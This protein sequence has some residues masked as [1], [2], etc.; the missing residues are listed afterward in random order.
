MK[1]VRVIRCDL[2][3]DGVIVAIDVNPIPKDVVFEDYDTAESHVLWLNEDN[4]EFNG[5]SQIM[6]LDFFCASEDSVVRVFVQ[7]EGSQHWLSA[8]VTWTDEQPDTVTQGG[9]DV[10]LLTEI[11]DT[12]AQALEHAG[13]LTARPSGSMINLKACLRAAHDKLNGIIQ[14]GSIPDTRGL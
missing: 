8:W 9:N 7:P 11:R 13:Q 5:T 4:E 3:H 1:T 10:G 14:R 2:N 6:D 12:V